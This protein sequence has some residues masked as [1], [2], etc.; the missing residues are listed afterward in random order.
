MNLGDSGGPLMI[1]SNA[2]EKFEL[3]AVTSFRSDCATEGVFTRVAPFA[4]WIWSIINEPTTTIRTT[5]ARITG[6]YKYEKIFIFYLRVNLFVLFEVNRIHLFVTQAIHVDVH[7]YQ[8]YFMMN[9]LRF[10]VVIKDESLVVKQLND[11]VGHGSYQ[12]DY[13]VPIVAVDLLSTVNGY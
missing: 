4:N 9:L 2:S 11:I 1:Y 7:L 13:L 8:L 10:I 3:V 12:Y 6:I 5:T